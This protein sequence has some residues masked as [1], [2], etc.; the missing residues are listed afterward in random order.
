MNCEECGRTVSG[1]LG[2]EEINLEDAFIIAVVEVSPRDWILCD[3]CNKLVCYNCCEYPKSGYCDTC[4]ARYN[5]HD[6]LVEAS[7]INLP[8]EV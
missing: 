1:D 8:D 3:A 2:I 6:Y 5:L 4:I 7:L